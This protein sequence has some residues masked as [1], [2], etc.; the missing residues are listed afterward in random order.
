MKTRPSMRTLTASISSKAVI[1]QVWDHFNIKKEWR[2]SQ[3]IVHGKRCGITENIGVPAR[4][5]S[6]AQ[7]A[8]RAKDSLRCPDRDSEFAWKV[9]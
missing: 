1:E 5:C 4:T 8:V 2:K 9:A 7:S 6:L 3:G